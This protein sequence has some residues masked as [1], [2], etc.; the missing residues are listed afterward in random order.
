LLDGAERRS[1]TLKS[2]NVDKAEE[3]LVGAAAGGDRE[4]RRELFERYRGPAYQVAYRITGRMEDALDVVQDSFISAF[5]NLGRF[6]RESGFKTWL[7]RIVTNRAL[8]LLRARRVRLAVPLDAGDEGEPEHSAVDLRPESSTPG[9]ALERRELAERL[10]QALEKLPPEQRVVFA[11]YATGDMTY[12]Q[13]AEVLGIP[14]GTVMSRLFHARR[15]LR[16]LVP[17][18]APERLEANEPG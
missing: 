17:E 5:E 10:S 16:E 8:D 13:I 1:N 2:A 15:R 11:L 3:G 14:V 9:A 6:Q 12:G 18:L 4:A 7:M